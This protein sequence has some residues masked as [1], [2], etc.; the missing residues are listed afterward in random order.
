M[1][2]ERLNPNDGLIVD[3]KTRLDAIERA[4]EGSFNDTPLFQDSN[5]RENLSKRATRPKESR[6]RILSRRANRMTTVRWAACLVLALIMAAAGIGVGIHLCKD[7]SPI[8]K[9]T[10]I[11]VVAVNSV[12]YVED[13][14]SSGGIVGSLTTVMD[15]EG[16]AARIEGIQGAE[17]SVSLDKEAPS[18]LGVEENG[19]PEA[20]YSLPEPSGESQIAT[21]ASW[22][23]VVDLATRAN[24]SYR[25]AEQAVLIEALRNCTF[26]LRQGNGVV[27]CC[28]DLSGLETDIDIA[29]YIQKLGDESA[30][31]FPLVLS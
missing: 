19:Q 16:A 3:L 15:A 23:E 29:T 7:T 9:S 6:Y 24:V 14:G 8:G 31:V 17:T 22:A 20:E 18:D 26:S 25:I 11:G 10:A 2:N 27:N 28:L 21:K 4:T 12:N 5:A 30:A 13:E 1:D